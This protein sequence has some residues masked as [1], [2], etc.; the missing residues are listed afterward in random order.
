MKALCKMI[1][2]VLLT[3]VVSP[4]LFGQVNGSTPSPQPKAAGCHEHGRR[5]P[6]PSPVTYQCCW[7]GHQVATLRNSADLRSRLLLLSPAIEFVAPGLA[8]TTYQA[9]LEPWSPTFGPPGVTSLR[10]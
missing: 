1:A 5:S 9:R 10:I 8:R 3:A 4:L 6:A 2:L 7:A